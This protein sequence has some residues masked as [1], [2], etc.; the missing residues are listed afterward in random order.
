MALDDSDTGRV[1]R[2]RSGDKA[3]FET[4][5]ERHRSMAR[6]VAEGQT[7]NSADVD[8]VVA[9]AFAS[10]FESLAAGKGPDTCF[11]AYLLT[12]VRRIAHKVN[13]SGSR[14]RPTDDPFVLDSPEVHHDPV[15]TRF[16][17]AAVAQAFKA[18]PER[19]R[20]VLW[21]VDIEGMKPA[22]ASKM[23]GLSANGV[24]SLALR[25]RERLRQVYLQQHVSESVSAD[26]REY[27]SQ[28]GAYAR[29]GLRKRSRE[30][31]RLHLE[32]C[33]R[34]T[35]RL[36]DLTD[37]QSP[38]RPARWSQPKPSLRPR[39]SSPPSSSTTPS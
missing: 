24:S 29:K 28:L 32:K 12:T 21:Y 4:L 14:T 7:D 22:A 9:D 20:A 2:V 23:L 34:C 11:R 27:S 36:L 26:C 39:K 6:H 31:V 5:F 15:M 30:R 37:V 8:D 19:W 38:M 35:A 13:R 16:E 17:S 33:T 25:A 1:E 10:V 18:L 3:A